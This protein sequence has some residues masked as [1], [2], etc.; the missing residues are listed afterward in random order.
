MERC[1]MGN[2]AKFPITK[3]EQS[4]GKKWIVSAVVSVLASAAAGSAMADINIGVVT[5]VTGG[6]A[7]LGAD[8][9]RVVDMIAA[10]NPTVAN[11]KI[12]LIFLDDA[13]DPTTSVKNTRKLISENKVDAILG[14]NVTGNA[15]AMAA[16]ANEEKVPMIVAG[17]MDVSGEKNKWVFRNSQGADLMVS[18][19]V[20]HMV[21]AKVKTV[22][23]IG[24]SD[25]WG[26]LLFK[27]LE[28][29]AKANNITIVAAERYNRP[30]TSVTPQVLKLISAKPEVV[31]VGGSG[32]AAV[33]PHATLV[34]RGYKGTV[35]HIHSV[36]SQEFLRVGGSKVEGAYV[37]VGGVLINE[38]LPDN[39][40]NKKAISQFLETYEGV[41]GKNTRSI[42]GAYAWDA[43]NLFKGAMAEAL[44]TSQPGTQAFR[45]AVR[46][47]LEKTKN[48]V[49]VSGVYNFSETDHV[50]LGDNSRVLVR[51]ENNKWV[52]QR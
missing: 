31:F 7:A 49:G 52:Y 24:F 27:E 9:K 35:Y 30:D 13:S 10:T 2:A 11:Q 15:I 38:Q 22:G 4:M 40:V 33:L 19:I 45:D 21:Q 34:D 6:T 28:K 39:F 47:N 8:V 46:S 1:S 37:P 14:S 29:G 51:I 42:F 20:E 12:N 26:D 23:F 36:A 41:Y 16:V 5:S 44:K 17:P 43:L 50:G 25:A 48:F 32:T 3:E 18:R